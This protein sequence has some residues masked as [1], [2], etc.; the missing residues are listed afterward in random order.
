MAH[1]EDEF[2]EIENEHKR[3]EN[4]RLRISIADNVAKMNNNELR[5]VN[6][7]SGNIKEFLNVIKV[8]KLLEDWS[9]FIKPDKRK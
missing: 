2:N 3:K 6:A 5:F 7:I 9:D 4:T 1:Y 8:M